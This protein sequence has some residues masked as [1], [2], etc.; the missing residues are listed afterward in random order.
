MKEELIE[1]ESP[2]RKCTFLFNVVLT[3]LCFYCVFT[4]WLSDDV[5]IN[6]LK[7]HSDLPWES[8]PWSNNFHYSEQVFIIC[9]TFI[10]IF[11]CPLIIKLGWNRLIANLFPIR[12]ITY[13]EAYTILLTFT[14]IKA[15]F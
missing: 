2:K 8:L 12:Y 3:L 14:T 5:K 1:A 4:S 9:N 11:L 7:N 10:F 15:V 13:A 6:K